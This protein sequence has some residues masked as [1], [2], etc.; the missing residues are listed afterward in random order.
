M[1]YG[2]VADIG[3]QGPITAVQSTSNTSI[4]VSTNAPKTINLLQ[5]KNVS[6]KALQQRKHA[7]KIILTDEIPHNIPCQHKQHRSSR[8]RAL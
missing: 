2:E 7:E 8:Q 5:F 6:F 4:K 1:K 3:R